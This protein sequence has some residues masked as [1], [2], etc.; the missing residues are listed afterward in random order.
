MKTL[1]ACVNWLTAFVVGLAGFANVASAAPGT[2][3]NVNFA[4]TGAGDEM[5][6]T[7]FISGTYQQAP[8]YYPGTTWND[9]VGPLIIATNSEPSSSFTRTGLLDSTGAPTSIGFTTASTTTPFDLEGPYS[10]ADHPNTKLINGGIRRVFNSGSG[11]ALNNRF[12]IS[13]LDDLKVY[14]IYIASS[15]NPNVKCS[16]QIGAGGTPKTIRNTTAIRTSQTWKPGDNWVVFYGVAPTAGTI[17]VRGVGNAGADGGAFSGLTLNGFQIV[18]ATGWLNPDKAIYDFGDPENNPGTSSVISNNNT[19]SNITWTVL[20]SANLSALSPTFTLADNATCSPPSGTTRNFSA[21][22]LNYSVTA[23]DGTTRVYS[24]T[25]VK[26]APSTASNIV[27]VTSGTSSAAVVGNTATL[28]LPVGTPVTS[29]APTIAVSPFATV[30]PGSGVPQNFTN[31]VNY[32]VTAQD[33]I[34]T[35]VYSVR[36]LQ[37]NN[38]TNNAGGNW[39]DGPGANWAP[40]TSPTPAATTNIVFNTAGTYSSNQDLAAPFQLNQLVMSAP[41]VSLTG[42]GLQFDGVDPKIIQSSASTIDIGIGLDLAVDTVL[43]GTGS[44]QVNIGGLIT[45]PGRLTKST[46][47]T[48]RLSTTNSYFGGTTILAGII[49]PNRVG[50]F[51]SGQVTL[52]GG[53]LFNQT[54]ENGT[55]FEGNNPGGAYPNTFFLSGG[56]VT[57]T[58]AFGGATDVWTNT[59]ISGPGSIVVVGDG[60]SQGLTLQGFNTFS[61]GLT[62]GLPNSTE[63]TNI[64]LFNVGSLG[65]GPLRSELKGSNLTIGGLRIQEDLSSGVANAIE[66]ATGARLVVNT[67]PEGSG[68]GTGRNVQFTGP[69]TGGGSL[70]KIGNGTMWLNGVSAYGGTTTVNGG[71]LRVTDPAQ[72][73]SGQLIIKLNSPGNAPA[74]TA[75]VDLDYVGVRRINALKIDDLDMPDG[76]YG[77]T[78]SGATNVD[79]IHF[80]G[81]GIVRVGPDPYA[82]WASSFGLTGSNAAPSFDFDKDGL[83][84]AVEFVVGT[85]P[86]T[87]SSNPLSAQ[88]SGGNVIFTFQRTVASKTPNVLLSIEV[89]PIL[90]DWQDVYAVPGATLAPFAVVPNGANETIILTVPRGTEPT[91]FGRLKVYITP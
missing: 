59:E 82:L 90:S 89:S 8:S 27:S 26:A 61:G 11:N 51:G 35:R 83:V 37:S 68:G 54:N 24:V 1:R 71:Y 49:K 63:G 91:K 66:L 14:N 56:P 65:T 32:T 64:Q 13:G 57:F 17:D 30:S 76:T 85:N 4:L 19:G 39:S 78:L 77:S 5:N 43:E 50:C 2:T 23:Q 20:F 18:E 46:P 21:G 87:S 81:T 29:L 6:G 28:Y 62:L 22:P 45:G 40:A 3:I 34:T 75:T 79:D 42:N 25:A 80:T 10:F 16:W 70:V 88:I 47:G 55:G 60:R 41:A 67:S 7:P 58:V 9:S 44:G 38:W 15:Q 52:A 33:G 73:A 74:S 31:P 36:V 86:T 53:V 48:L 84:N 69:I 12:T 72:L